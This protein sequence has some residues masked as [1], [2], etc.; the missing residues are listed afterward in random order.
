MSHE[1]SWNIGFDDVEGCICGSCGDPDKPYL[2]CDLCDLEI[3]PADPGFQE[4]WDQVE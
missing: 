1:H 2:I 4:L 3:T